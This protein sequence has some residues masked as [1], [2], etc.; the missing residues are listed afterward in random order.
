M[1]AH[2]IVIPFLFANLNGQ[3]INMVRKAWT[4][5]FV[6]ITQKVITSNKSCF[7]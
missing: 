5:I 1:L 2:F 3:E 6:L 7:T 4:R